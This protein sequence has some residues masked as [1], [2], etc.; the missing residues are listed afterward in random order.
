MAWGER[1]RAGR[2]MI[3]VNAGDGIGVGISLIG[4]RH[5]LLIP[6]LGI[7]SRMVGGCNCVV[8]VVVVVVLCAA[9]RASSTGTSI[10][11]CR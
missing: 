8:V 6:L 11:L 2:G 1:F 4:D 5:L 7:S 10:V 3:G 9:L